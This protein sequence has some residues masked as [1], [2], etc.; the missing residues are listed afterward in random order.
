MGRSW[1]RAAA[2]LNA[3]FDRVGGQN[4][5]RGLLRGTRE[6]VRILPHEERPGNSVGAA[7]IANRLRDRENVRFGE[8]AVGA[9]ALAQ[10][11]QPPA[12]PTSAAVRA[13]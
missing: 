4:L 10:R 2:R 13:G 7:V 12:G 9:A 8:G 5:E 6:R 3:G 1:R 11:P